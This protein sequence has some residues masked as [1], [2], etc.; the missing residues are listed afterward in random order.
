VKITNGKF[1]RKIRGSFASLMM[2]KKRDDKKWG[3]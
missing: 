2:T 3:R 1:G